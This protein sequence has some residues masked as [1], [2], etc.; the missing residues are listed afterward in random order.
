MTKRLGKGLKALIPEYS[1]EEDRYM[2]DGIPIDS[3]IPNSSQPR[4]DFSESAMKNLINSIRENGILQPLTLRDLGNGKYELIAGE[5]RWRA[6]EI[7][8][9]EAVPGY[10]ISIEADVEMLE[11]AMVENVQRENLNAVEEAEGYA[12]LSGKYNMTQDQ[13]AKKVGKKRTTISNILRLLKLPPEIKRS[14]RKGDISAGHARAILQ[15]RKSTQMQ[16]LF[17]KVIQEKLS[18]R[19]VEEIASNLI[20]PQTTIKTSKKKTRKFSIITEFENNLISTLGTKVQI[21]KTRKGAGKISI[22][23]YSKDDLERILEL[24][25][26]IKK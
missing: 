22:S 12:I 3:I 16:N 5:R 19:Q 13:I 7:A 2:E 11:Y 20:K 15:L 8:G 4:Q 9:L 24:I 21:H 26:S 6:A 17:R 18:V 14:L 23:F 10:I 25:S 1:S